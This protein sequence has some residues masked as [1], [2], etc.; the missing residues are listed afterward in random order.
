MAFAH[1]KIIWS[2][3]ISLVRCRLAGWPGHFSAGQRRFISYTSEVKCLITEWPRITVEEITTCYGNNIAKL[4]A[5]VKPVFPSPT[6]MLLTC[7]MHNLPL[8]TRSSCVESALH[9]PH[10]YVSLCISS[11]K[12]VGSTVSDWYCCSTEIFVCRIR[13]S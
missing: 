10:V 4:I 11:S 3:T 7:V 6:F 1:R 13:C 5:W 8:I 12:A 2:R 9:I